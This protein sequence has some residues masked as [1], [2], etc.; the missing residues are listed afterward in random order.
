MLETSRLLL[1]PP[2]VADFERYLPLWHKSEM[3]AA[4]GPNLSL[5]PEE[6]WA[7]LLRFVGHWAHFGYGLFLVEDFESHELIGEVGFAH[8]HRGMGARFDAVPEAAWRVLARRRKRGIAVEGM[9]AAISWFEQTVRPER[10]VCMIHPSNAASLTVAG[11]LGFHE[12]ER[13]PYKERTVI[14]LERGSGS[15]AAVGD[16]PAAR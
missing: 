14:L 16:A 9:Q 10:T 4:P 2:R 1:R 11:R 13:A 5:N 12:F 15:A 7:R 8:F 6:V 3:A